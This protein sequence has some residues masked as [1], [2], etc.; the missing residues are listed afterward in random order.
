MPDTHAQ[1]VHSG[2]DSAGG[3]VGTPSPAPSPAPSMRPPRGRD[4]GAGAGSRP[5][6][7]VR[8]IAAVRRFVRCARAGATGLAAAAAAVITVAA[9]AFVSDSAWLVDQRDVLKSASDAAGIAATLEMER[10]LNNDPTISNAD[11]QAILEQVAKRYVLLNLGHLDADRYARAEQTLVLQVIPNRSQRT[12]DVAAEADLGGIF[13]S[14]LLPFMAE[15]VVSE[16]M[17]VETVIETFIN[18]IEVVLAIDISDSMAKTLDGRR[19]RAVVWSDALNTAVVEERTSRM[20]VVKLAAMNLTDILAPSE[21]ARVAIGVVP[22]TNA[23]RLDAQARDRWERNDWAR[24]PTSRTYGAP[25]V[26]TGGSQLQCPPLPP[27]TQTVASSPPAPW[28]GC[29]DEHRTG[30]VGTLAALPAADELLWP[31]AMSAFAQNYFA[32]HYGFSYECI[33]PSPPDMAYQM[34]YMP[35]ISTQTWGNKPAQHPCESPLLDPPPPIRPL[36]TDSEQVEQAIDALVPVGGGTYSTLGV[37]WA[38]R[39]LEHSWKDV[40]EG[41]NHPADPGD[42]DNVDLRKAIVLLTDGVDNYCGLADPGCDRG[43]VGVPIQVAC[44]VA[45][46]AGSEIFVV[47]AMTPEHVPQDLADRLYAC[48][49]QSD[50]PDGTYVFVDNADPEAL[51]AAFA[52]IAD[53]LRTVRRVY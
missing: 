33:A 42:R 35:P 34:C 38:Q 47:T 19:Q 49:S 52:D 51:L 5:A 36:S 12:V 53:Q 30:S 7:A 16:R 18:P 41:V 10:Q 40:W 27:S 24:Y 23:V 22:W 29:L 44:D 11:L 26:C 1:Y 39:M 31:P 20:E 21:E 2:F 50:N 6:P 32:A 8:P 28:L 46:A 45:K 25:Y 3:T 15:S 14:R 37:L 4:A 17:R 9:S 13:M 48:S 43:D